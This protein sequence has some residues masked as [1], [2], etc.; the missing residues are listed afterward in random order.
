MINDLAV[1]PVLK[2]LGVVSYKNNLPVKSDLNLCGSPKDRLIND[3][4]YEYQ[5]EI[6]YFH[7]VINA[8]EIRS[9]VF[10]IIFHTLYSFSISKAKVRIIIAKIW[11]CCKKVALLF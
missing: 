10:N 11:Q 8:A 1:Q 7:H 4:R 3:F 5:W 2:G 9:D 6:I